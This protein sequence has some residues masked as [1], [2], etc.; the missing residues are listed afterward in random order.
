VVEGG[1]GGGGGREGGRGK[2]G[3]GVCVSIVFEWVTVGRG[4]GGGGGGYYSVSYSTVYCNGESL[5][6]DRP[7][8]VGLLGYGHS[9]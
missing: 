1:T 8:R 4:R 5:S 3:G 6:E 7:R 2:E 9:V